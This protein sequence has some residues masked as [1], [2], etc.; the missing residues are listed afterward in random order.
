MTE[1]TLEKL[2]KK[3]KEELQSKNIIIWGANERGNLVTQLLS[4]HKLSPIFFIDNDTQKYNTLFLGKQ[5]YNVRELERFRPDNCFIIIAISYYYRDV[6]DTLEQF[7]YKENVHYFY[8][9]KYKKVKIIDIKNY[10]ENDCNQIIG[11]PMLVN[12]EI[13]FNGQNNK[14]EFAEDVRLENVKINFLANDGYCFIG[15]GSTF[16]GTISIGLGC[17][18]YIGKRLTVTHNCLITTSEFVEA[19]IGDDCMFASANQ[20]RCDDAHPIFDVET[21]ERL[22]KSRS[23]QI[24]NHVWLAYGATVLSGA[25]IEE[26]SVIGHSSVVKGHIPNNVIAV[27]NPAKVIKSNIAWDKSHLSITPPHQFPDSNYISD[28]KYWNLTSTEKRR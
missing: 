14:I 11:E 5:V 3:H 6:F 10:Q 2:I 18:V 22:N 20:I 28:K 8:F 9:Y 25:S 7:G 23:I 21:G 27:G 19:R 4:T 12:S 16:K 15:E 13:M 17:S 26:G 1:N 24:G